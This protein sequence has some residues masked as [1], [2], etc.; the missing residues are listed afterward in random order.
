[1]REFRVLREW[2]K[3]HNAGTTDKSRI[4]GIARTLAPFER[5][6]KDG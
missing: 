2:A 5:I 4:P 1:M 6:H 3:N